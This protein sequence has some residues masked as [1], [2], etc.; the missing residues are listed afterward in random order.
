MVKLVRVR[1][2][3]KETN[4]TRLVCRPLADLITW[5]LGPREKINFWFDRWLSQKIR[6]ANAQVPKEEW[7]KKVKD[8]WIDCKKIGLG[9]VAL[10]IA[11]KNHTTT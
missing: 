8:Y 7:E 11:L 9:Q 4:L 1:A 2:S 10:L 3:W 6:E 5:K